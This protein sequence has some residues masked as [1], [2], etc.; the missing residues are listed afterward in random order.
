[1]VAAPL[2]KD[3]WPDCEFTRVSDRARTWSCP[4]FLAFV[5]R[6]LA[7]LYAQPGKEFCA[8]AA[9]PRATRL[10]ACFGRAN[11]FSWCGDIHTKAP[12]SSGAMQFGVKLV[13]GFVCAITE[14]VH[15]VAKC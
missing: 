14:G 13:R 12:M 7:H 8:E 11:V 3:Y 10:S 9:P 6:E 15:M 1:M 5:L 2:E 4:F